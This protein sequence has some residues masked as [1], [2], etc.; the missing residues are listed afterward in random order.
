VTRLL[1]LFLSFGALLAAAEAPSITPDQALKN[2]FDGNARYVT[3][4]AIHPDQ[5]TARRIEVVAGQH[6]F[7][8][9]LGCADSR[10][11]PELIFD[12][13]LG[14]LFV[15]RVA[16]N[17]ASPEILGSIEY[18]V[19]HLGIPLVM[20][21]GHEKCGAVKATADHAH[22]DIHVGTLVKAIEPAVQEARLQKGDLIHNAVACNVKRGVRIIQTATPE[23][24]KLIA[25]GKLKVI[26][27]D[28]DLATG[29]VELVK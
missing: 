4:K 29:K 3:N 25:A 9:V 20:V 12:Q 13:G 21:L 18:A 24:K 23:L 5:T 1:V 26:G 16:G 15:L 7:A 22:G 10:V 17:I 28:Y 27:A 11:P 6:P 2:L 8:V 19:E 14:D